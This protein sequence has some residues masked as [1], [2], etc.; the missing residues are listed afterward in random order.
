MPNSAYNQLQAIHAMLASGH[1]SIRVGRHSLVLWGLVGGALV[2]VTDLIITPERFP[3]HWGRALAVLLFLGGVLGVTAAFDFY[4]TRRQILERGESVPFVHTQVIKV[5]WLLLVMGVLFT[6]ASAFFG[7]GYMT[8]GI[9]LVL[10]GLGLY[11]H[12]LFSEQ[13]LEWV[14][15]TMIV[16]GVLPLTLKLPYEVT[17][18]LA[19]SALG[20]GLPLF[21]L[22]FMRDGRGRLSLSAAQ[23]L[24]W[25]GC[26]L[27]PPV[28]A[29]QYLKVAPPP[30][31][32]NVS[33][34]EYLQGAGDDGTQIVSLPTGTEIPIRLTISADIA[35]TN[36]AIIPLR[37][38][39]PMEVLLVNGKP[40]GRVRLAGEAW[41]D[42]RF[43][44]RLQGL[45]INATLNTARG[46][47]AE[48]A[49]GIT[50]HN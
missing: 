34:A 35:E 41:K 25:L 6:F 1:R 11:V 40:D 43:S 42:L 47:E 12:G 22:L 2:Y 19:A 37:L 48:A 50:T 17:K 13:P 27:A 46:P 20:V 3:T 31:A 23:A 38:T 26:V 45:Q 29:Y 49:I 44:F 39:Q 9:W 4:Y 16:L 30:T 33:L 24:M 15:V 14:G 32:H 36:K 10:I 8:Y 21:A 5:W 7:G 28:L 18:W